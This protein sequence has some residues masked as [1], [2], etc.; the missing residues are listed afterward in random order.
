M[1]S[2]SAGALR[3]A[4]SLTDGEST[5]PASAQYM[6]QRHHF[7]GRG[8]PDMSRTRK[9]HGVRRIFPVDKLGN[10]PMMRTD[11]PAGTSMPITTA[12]RNED[13]TCDA[14]V[15]ANVEIRTGHGGYALHDLLVDHQRPAPLT[16]T[17]SATRA[18]IAAHRTR[19]LKRC[20]RTQAASC[21]A[22]PIADAAHRTDNRCA[23][24]YMEFSLLA[25]GEK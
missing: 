22:W 17:L 18:S 20:H 23:N 15:P 4:S 25:A 5:H 19:R 10:S 12:G 11:E 13:T 2:K 3:Q 16:S 14:A 7:V 6:Q 9:P 1:L 21:A 24:A 8:M